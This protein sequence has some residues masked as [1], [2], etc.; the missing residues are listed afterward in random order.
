VLYFNC[1]HYYH[2]ENKGFFFCE[3]S[4]INFHYICIL[5]ICICYLCHV[6]RVI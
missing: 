5:Y 2:D 4:F 1:T 6:K 3:E